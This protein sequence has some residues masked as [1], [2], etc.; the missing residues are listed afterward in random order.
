L[1]RS[2]LN[3]AG[4]SSAG[5]T[6]PGL[7]RGVAAA[8]LL[9]A[10]GASMD[11]CV[12]LDHGHVLANAQSGN[13]VLFALHL[14]AGEFGSALHHVPSFFAFCCGV[15]ASRLSGARLR[16]RLDSRPVRLGVEAVA[17]A[18][19][20]WYAARMPDG[21]V[22]TVVAF[23]AGLQISSYSRLEGWSF[24]TGMTTGNL[25]NGLTALTEALATRTDRAPNLRKAGVLGLLVVSF[26]AGAIGAGYATLHLHD[27][28]LFGTAGLVAAAAALL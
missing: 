4:I 15:V 7:K 21:V 20:A 18:A 27:R 23:L 3:T 25:W 12:Y 19:L 14:A 5:D 2:R 24:N 1:D 17:L 8:C 26:I 13:L 10:A 22:V 11:A 16:Q 9:T 28:A 6:K